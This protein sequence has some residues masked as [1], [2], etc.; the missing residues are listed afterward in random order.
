MH[1][2]G[3]T[4]CIAGKIKQ[5]K[6]KNLTINYDLLIFIVLLLITTSIHQAIAH[7]QVSSLLLKYN[8]NLEEISFNFSPI[9]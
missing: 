4:L 1:Q 8:T 2:F 9:Y 5:R 6:G 7:W 3:E